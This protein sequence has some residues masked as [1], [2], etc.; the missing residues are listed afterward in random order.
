MGDVF[1]LHDQE[2]LAELDEFEGSDEYRRVLTT[3]VLGEWRSRAVQGVRVP[4]LCSGGRRI[5]SGDWMT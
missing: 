3:A 2:T 4:R 5:V 1:Q